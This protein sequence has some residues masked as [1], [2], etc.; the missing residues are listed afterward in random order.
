VVDL[1]IKQRRGLAGILAGIILFAIIFTAGFGFLYYVN[2]S[3]QIANQANVQRENVGLQAADEKLLVTAN[4]TSVAGCSQCLLVGATNTGGE[5][6]SVVDAFVTCQSKSCGQY[7]SSQLM[8]NSTVSPP[9]HFLSQKPDLNVSLPLTLGVGA[10]AGNGILVSG[11]PGGAF[12]YVPKYNET[13]VVSLLTSRGNVFSAQYPP[14][15][16]TNTTD[17]IVHE[18]STEVM[19]DQVGGGPQLSL[20]LTASA[21]CPG[22]T[23]GCTQTF[24]C[25]DGCITV[26]ATVYNL[27]SSEATG[28]SVSLGA[29]SVGGTASVTPYS[30]PLC[31]FS[32]GGTTT[33]I[34]AD[35]QVTA[36]CQF[37]ANTGATGGLASFSGTASGT[38][39]FPVTSANSVSNSI[40]IGGL[41]S[42]TTQGAFAAN[43]F[44]LKYSSCY[45]NT[46]GNFNSTAGCQTNVNPVTLSNLPDA[47]T[48]AAGS[49]FYVAFYVQATNLLNAKI[50][51]LQYSYTYG[52]PA[53][54]AD[55]FIFLAGTNSSMVNGVY[56]PDYS[57]TPS[58]VGYPTGCQTNPTNCIV[59]NP[60]QTVTLTFAAC[61]YGSTNW[62]WGNYQDAK[63]FGS[64]GGCTG[65]PLDLLAPEAMPLGV[66][67]TYEYDGQPYTQLMPFQAQQYIRSSGVEV[68][69]T[70]SAVTAGT[71]ST[72]T[73]TVLDT[74]GFPK[75]VPPSGTVSFSGSALGEGTFNST[76]C[77]TFF[78]SCSVTYTPNTD[79]QGGISVKATYQ[80]DS[81]Y[82]GSSNGTSVTALDPTKTTLSGSCVGASVKVNIQTTCTVTVTDVTGGTPSTPTGTVTMSDTPSGSGVFGPCTLSQVTLGTASCTVT[83]QPSSG[84]EGPITITATFNGDSA[85]GGSSGN[86]GLTATKRTS[87]ITVSCSPASLPVS[88]STTCTATVLDT[89]AG[90][91]ITPTGGTVTF[92]ASPSGSG[93]FTP[94]S[95]QCTTNAGTCT[96][97]FSPGTGKGGT[98]VTITAT[99]AGDTD[100]TG[101]GPSTGFPLT[102]TKITTSTSVTCSP[103]PDAD[104]SATTC[105]AT[106]SDNGGATETPTGTITFSASPADGTFSATTCNLSGGSCH[107]NFTPNTATSITITASYG[108]DGDHLTSSGSTTLSVKRPTSTTLS[109]VSPVLVNHGSTCTVTV[110]DTGGSGATTPTGT[111]TFSASP[112]DGTFSATSCTLSSGSC[113]VTFTPN[114]VTTITITASYGGD[115]VHSTSSGTSSITV[116]PATPTIATTL[117]T[118]SV[119]A[120]G[121]VTDSATLSG[122]TSNAG[123]TVQYEYFTSSTCSGSATDLGSA[124]T[125]N[126]GNVPGS[127]SQQFSAAGSYGLEAVYSGDS[128]NNGAT[129][130]CEALTITQPTA[131][132]ASYSNS[133]HRVTFGGSGSGGGSGFA[134]STTYSYCLSSSSSSVSNCV[135]TTVGTF[136]STSTGTVPSTMFSVPSQDRGGTWYVLIYETTGAGANTVITE[137]SVTT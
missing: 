55:D 56:Y 77:T 44:F 32:G 42:V 36:T 100:H 106:V 99:Y 73:A 15:P 22:G 17:V 98:T 68:S 9:S 62:A 52:D 70:P 116:H 91:P 126:N 124:V 133:N 76:T 49:N 27:A 41:S 121:S 7:S 120:G 125:V 6:L 5:S 34:P 113:S 74:D 20:S 33:D 135:A 67:I 112:A 82:A 3:T 90:T 18:E 131:P 107:V 84:K 38:L 40:E 114:T 24:T 23:P 102:V 37:S 132:T 12:T 64:S 79:S 78:G 2:S 11:G 54:S 115:S 94:G 66:V 26:S 109:C 117:S 28:V 130:G 83:Y 75:S 122:E 72:C 134:D 59:A 103:N 35:S 69:C 16:L 50:S 61:G 127:P 25:S 101:S 29:P 119:G 95:A 8:S 89:S 87:S 71:P 53:S 93:S 60:G 46:G 58:L 129:S 104:N 63:E 123:G 30:S 118:T 48:M 105:T 128:N 21:L 1:K 13:F 39:G 10:S 19:L 111:V 88:G 96:V 57:G 51:I 108:G 80:G 137:T 47:G 14:P 85:H 110:T 81:T 92:S 31:T 136:T 97:T 4:L 65:S 45:Q 86:T 43:F